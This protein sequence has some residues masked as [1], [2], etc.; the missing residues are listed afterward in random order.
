VLTFYPWERGLFLKA[1]VG[2]SSAVATTDTPGT[3]KTSDST[4]GANVAF[5]VGYAFWLG[6]GFNL[7]GN[8]DWSRQAYSGD[9]LDRADFWR[10]GVGFG[11]Y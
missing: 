11:W 4:S 7:S 6:K 9:K 2:I 8:L 5:G 1:G 10:L 3:G